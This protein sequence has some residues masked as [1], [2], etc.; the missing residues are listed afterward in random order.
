M[1]QRLAEAILLVIISGSLIAACTD[2]SGASGPDLASVAFGTGG[3]DC[4]LTGA[5]STFPLGANVHAVAT[6]SPA[7]ETGSTVMITVEL[8]GQELVDYRGTVK[9][10][11]PA[12]CIHGTFSQL[13]P[14]H[15]RFQ[16]AI[17]P[18]MIPPISG[19]FDVTQ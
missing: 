17:D 3:S 10:K 16:Y 15:Y 1:G 19:E 8:D 18:S 6:F 13:D 5:A 12:P 9:I 7:L 2:P 4:E 11:E 14:G